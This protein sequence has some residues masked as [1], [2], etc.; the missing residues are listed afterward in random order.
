[1]RSWQKGVCAVC[2]PVSYQKESSGAT[3]P[4]G[5]D[6]T[7]RQLVAMLQAGRGDHFFIAWALARYAGLVPEV[8][9]LVQGLAANFN[10]EKRTYVL[11]RLARAKLNLLQEDGAAGHDW[12]DY[13][14]RVGLGNGPVQDSVQLPLEVRVDPE[15]GRLAIG[16]DLTAPFRIWLVLRHHYG[17]P[18]WTDRQTLYEALQHAG[19]AHSRRHY[20]RLL[21]EG[22]GVFWGL[23]GNGRVW[24]RGSIRVVKEITQ[25]A[26]RDNADLIRTNVPGVRDV[27][28]RVDGSLKRFKARLYAGWLAHRE[29]PKIARATL[30]TLFG[31]TR[32]TLWA[33]EDELGSTLQIVPSYTQTAVDPKED[34]RIVDYIPEHAY[35]YLTRQHQVRIRWQSPNVY[36]TRLI[37]QHPCKGQSRKVRVTV[38]KI[39]RDSQPAENR[40]GSCS[41]KQ[42]AFGR[43]HWEPRQYFATGERLRQFLKGWQARGITMEALITPQTP[44]QVYRGIDRNEYA[45]YELTLDGELRTG[46]WER[47]SIRKEWVWRKAEAQQLQRWKAMQAG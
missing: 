18:G 1:L 23:G 8:E 30:C 38:T 4:R 24:L 44:R 15:L 25:W 41:E 17:N 11:N 2:L 13:G 34:D 14:R 36:R 20:N 37:R 29:S 39:I 21:Q 16:L 43:A 19:I 10:S 47:I 28:V 7:I 40:A 5:V 9:P 32:E 3:L 35:N 12:G 42:L 6:A 22:S 31:C 46:A 27:Y 45:I 26:L 33:W